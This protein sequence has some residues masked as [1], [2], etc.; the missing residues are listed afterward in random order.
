[1]QIPLPPEEF[2]EL[3]DHFAPSLDLAQWTS[4][5]ILDPGGVLHNPDHLHLTQGSIGFLWTSAENAKNQRRIIGTAE[6]GIPASGGKWQ[7]A[8]ALH[9]IVGWFGEIPDF[10][11]TLDAR[12]VIQEA[13]ERDFLRLLEHELYHCAQAVDTYGMKKFEKRTGLPVWGMRGHDVEEFI[14]VVRRYGGN[15]SV[16]DLVAAANEAPTVGRYQI[17]QA[18]GACLR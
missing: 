9:Q 8:R 17:Q 13:N 5:N 3:N 6:L 16:Q 11:I 15:R 10:I 7:K 4:V 1:V 18:C 12:F 14:G 2:L